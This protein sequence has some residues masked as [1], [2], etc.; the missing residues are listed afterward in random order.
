MQ[1]QENA[2]EAFG[3]YVYTT[4]IFNY[5]QIFIIMSKPLYVDMA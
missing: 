5:G 4:N 2:S 1:W 3:I